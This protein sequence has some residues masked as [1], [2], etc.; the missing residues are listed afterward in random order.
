VEN[1]LGMSR[2]EAGILQPKWD[3]CD[4]NELIF[5]VIKVNQ[6]AAENHPITFQ[7]NETL[8]LFKLDSGMMEQILH[9][10]LHNALQHTPTNTH[11]K[12]VAKNSDEGCVITISDSGTGFPEEEIG[13]V[14]DKFYRLNNTSPGGTGLGLSIAKGFTE[15][16]G[17]T[18]TLK[19]KVG[20]GAL[21]TV[22]IPTEISST[23]ELENEQGGDIDN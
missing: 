21:F 18:I 23:N 15:A 1:L 10:I 3:W 17:G 11:I 19:N 14:F 7:P 16:L 13:L 9:N 8:P 6:E 22:C 20:G 5:S 2:L 4:V 12:I